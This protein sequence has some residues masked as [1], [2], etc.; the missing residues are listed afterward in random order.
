[1]RVDETQAL[2]HQS[3][4]AQG[5]DVPK[6]LAAGRPATPN[7]QAANAPQGN[8]DMVLDIPVQMSVELGRKKVPIK[9]VL[10]LKPG[11]VVELDSMAGEPIDVLVN[12]YLIA[13]GEMVVVNGK[14]GIRLTDVVTPS[15][16][17]KRSGK[18]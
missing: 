14:F 6:I 18:A 9:Q 1:M 13:Q 7:G 17:F 5:L 4:W 8:I 16:R 10:E 3:G 15:E 2:D 11:S 12:G